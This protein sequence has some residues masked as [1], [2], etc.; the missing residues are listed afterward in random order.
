MR[1]AL[2]LLCAAFIVSSADATPP[3]PHPADVETLE[4]AKSVQFLLGLWQGTDAISHRTAK[5]EAA[6]DWDWNEIFLEDNDRPRTL[7]LTFDVISH[8]FKL[9]APKEGGF[10]LVDVS[11]PDPHALVWVTHP[12]GPSIRSTLVYNHGTLHETDALLDEDGTIKTEVD[13]TFDRV[14]STELWFSRSP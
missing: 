10:E 4:A 5:I 7:I 6:I 12:D 14:G 11:Q 9:F 2:M 8:G 3:P 1:S 13:V